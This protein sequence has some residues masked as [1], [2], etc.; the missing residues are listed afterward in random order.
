MDVCEGRALV[1]S[2]SLL[3]TARFESHEYGHLEE[4][5][6]RLEAT[7]HHVCDAIHNPKPPQRR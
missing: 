1:A 3:A 7:F 6:L 2:H 4:P 5:R